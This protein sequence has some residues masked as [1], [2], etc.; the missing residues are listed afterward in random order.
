VQ[1]QQSEGT[2]DHVPVYQLEILKRPI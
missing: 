2:V 1:E